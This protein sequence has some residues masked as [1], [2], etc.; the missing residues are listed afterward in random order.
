MMKRLI[1]IVIAVSAFMVGSGVRMAAHE[2]HDHK[3][4]GTVT[5][6]AADHVML[7][8]KDGKDVTV[9][10]T[11]AT[12]VKSKPALKVEEIKAGTRVV[13]TATQ[14]KDKSFKAKTIEVGVAAAIAK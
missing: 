13:I 7:K 1:A 12:K 14:E 6:A 4:M 3:I 9:Q 2:G 10:V 11:K 5:M 8:D